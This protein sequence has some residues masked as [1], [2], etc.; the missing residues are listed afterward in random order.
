MSVWN[1]QTTASM[2][3]I[4]LLDLIL[5]V[6]TL[7]FKFLTQMEELAMVSLITQKISLRSYQTHY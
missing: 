7:G 6:V 5:A 2:T 4:I 3:A 1:K